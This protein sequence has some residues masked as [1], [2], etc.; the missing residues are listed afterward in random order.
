MI[1]GLIVGVALV[2]IITIKT[3]AAIVRATPLWIRRSATFVLLVWVLTWGRGGAP[4]SSIPRVHEADLPW[5]KFLN[6]H[7][8]TGTP[9][10]IISARRNDTALVSKQNPLASPNEL[11]YRDVARRLV[12]ECG[13]TRVNVMSDTIETFLKLLE[14]TGFTVC[15]CIVDKVP[16]VFFV[17]ATIKVIKLTIFLLISSGSSRLRKP[18]PGW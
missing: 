8:L 9:V 17:G 11:A 14:D 2:F 16:M 5:E 12:S 15:V 6:E 10:I 18:T 3:C 1:A 4:F 7:L 13:H